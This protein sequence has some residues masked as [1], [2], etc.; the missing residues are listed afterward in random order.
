MR[1]PRCQRESEPAATFCPACEAPLLLRDEPEIPALDRALDLDRRLH[2]DE[3]ALAPGELD[4][5]PF[6]ADEEF[7]IT[8]PGLELAPG[9]P[10]REEATLDP[11][12][13]LE[14]HCDL[15]PAPDLVP[16]W[17]RAGAWAVDGALLAAAAAPPLLAAAAG[18]P[19]SADPLGALAPSALGFGAL[20][21]FAYAA[22]AHA[23]MGA[24]VGKRLLGLKVACP[25]GR[26]PTLGRTAIRAAVAVVGSAALGLGPL[27]ALFTRR[28]RGL[29]DLLS[30]TVV[31]RAA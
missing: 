25:D 18:L 13:H 2:R 15:D 9:G 11:A 26:S 7:E 23:L 20:L 29:H 30:G 24:T 8:D 16:S 27:L 17:R 10:C 21:G 4:L 1:C 12:P 31:V 14:P 28:G 5:P 22:L 6:V 19:P 3:Q